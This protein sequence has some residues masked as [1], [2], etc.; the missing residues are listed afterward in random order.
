MKMTLDV[1]WET[2]FTVNNNNCIVLKLQID[3]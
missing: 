2:L 1:I 3:F